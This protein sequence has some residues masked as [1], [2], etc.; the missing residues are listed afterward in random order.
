MPWLRSGA[1]LGR[2]IATDICQRP[3]QSDHETRRDIGAPALD[4]A[5]RI[6]ATVLRFTATKLLS[7]LEQLHLE[8]VKGGRQRTLHGVGADSERAL[9]QV[10]HAR[11]QV[12]ATRQRNGRSGERRR[13]SIVRR[14]IH[15]VVAPQSLPG[16]YACHGRAATS[17]EAMI[18][19]GTDLWDSH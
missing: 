3:L 2:M 12:C 1:R 5:Q 8:I 7:A 9:E 18:D 14:L 4:L 13:P 15:L 17:S 10:H 11:R 19:G 6:K 16:F